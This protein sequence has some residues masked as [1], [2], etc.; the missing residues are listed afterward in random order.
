M[1]F[2]TGFPEDMDL[3]LTNEKGETVGKLARYGVWEQKPGR[4][5]AE[6]IDTDDDLGALAARHGLEPKPIIVG[7][8]RS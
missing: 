8:G 5:K 6:V 7:R 4:H 2:I 1:K 3:T